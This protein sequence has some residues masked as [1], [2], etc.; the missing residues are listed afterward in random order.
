MLKKN[1]LRIK[2]TNM[3]FNIR[4]YN[5]SSPKKKKREVSLLRCLPST[6]YPVTASSI[7]KHI[8]LFSQRHYSLTTL[9]S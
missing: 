9:H 3:Q 1:A 6:V 4:K 8:Q 7:H 5:K 2:P